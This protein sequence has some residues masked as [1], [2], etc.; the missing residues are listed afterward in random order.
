LVLRT[1]GVVKVARGAIFIDGAY[2]DF[3]LRDEFGGTR[4]DYAGL[5][6][7][8]VPPGVD[9]LRTYYYNCPP[10]QD[11]P[12]TSEQRD[13]QAKFDRF[14][15]TLLG[16]SRFEVRLGKLA[17]RGLGEDGRPRFEQKQVDILLGVDLVSLSAKGQITE[18]ILLVGDSDFLPAIG[19][20]K[21]DGILIRLFHG[22]S[23]HR[24][25]IAAADERTRIDRAFVNSIVRPVRAGLLV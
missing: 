17:Y 7:L 16:L 8:M 23:P 14:Q 15:G 19:A 13:R 9:L 25:L 6:R 2:L 22:Q 1:E 5:V 10:Y 12:P 24:A 20:A 3:M 21:N 4:I 18:A 11:N